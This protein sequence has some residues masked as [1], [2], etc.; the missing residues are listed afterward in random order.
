MRIQILISSLLVSAFASNVQAQDHKQWPELVKEASIISTADSSLQSALYFIPETDTSTPLLVALHTWSSDFKQSMSI[1]YATWS[2]QKQWA[3]IHP[4]Y[5]GP[6]SNPKSAGSDYVVQDIL[7]AIQFMKES[8]KID[9]NRIYL[10][11]GS[12]GGYN[13]LQIVSRIPDVWAGVSAMVPI[14]DLE[15]W[16]LENTEADR[17][18][19]DDIVLATG[20][21][22]GQS[23]F[24]NRQ[25][26]LRS[27]VHHLHQADVVPIDIAA[28]IRDGHTGSVPVSHSL[29]G[30]NAL[31][32]SSDQIPDSV[33]SYLTIKAEIPTYLSQANPDSTYPSDQ[34][35][36]FRKVSNNVRITL[37][38]GSHDV[39]FETGLKW[40]EKQRKGQGAVFE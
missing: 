18:Y 21:K 39:L 1:P 12:G 3:F 9:I 4:D 27:P 31:A 5:H 40:L 36:L 34:Q 32:N 7:D 10:M 6:N 33:I 20:G 2:V 19:A 25:Y 15:A 26:Y 24:T 16:Y 13:A 8:G 37:F 17:A 29:K 11:G 30:F 38:D 22:P 14:T 23:Y 35:P 28:G